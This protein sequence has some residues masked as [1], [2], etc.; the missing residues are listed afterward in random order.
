M[1]DGTR[2]VY[3]SLLGTRQTV[4]T[5]GMSRRGKNSVTGRIDRGITVNV[6]AQDVTPGRLIPVRITQLRHNTLVGE[7]ETR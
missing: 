2:A 3:E 1:E 6:Q 7:E 4:L 5:D